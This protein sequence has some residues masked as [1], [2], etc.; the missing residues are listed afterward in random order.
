MLEVF[1][2]PDHMPVW[3]DAARGEA[4]D[5]DSILGDY[6]ATVDWPAASFWS[7]LL[8]ENPGALVVLSTRSDANAWWH[9]ANSTIFGG[10]GGTSPDPEDPFTQMWLAI[11]DARFTPDWRE[12]APA[13]AAYERHNVQVRAEAPPDQ[14]LE[15][16]PGD[17]WE[18][19]CTALG[20]PV[21]DEPFPHH[22]STEDFRQMMG[23]DPLES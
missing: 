16:Q 5:W 3:R 13:I 11:C 17:G 12:E 23:M 18:P 1:Q 19:L 7:D 4:V 15:W 20:V 9:S 6:V 14:L 2:H 22:N 10:M 21:P 8:V